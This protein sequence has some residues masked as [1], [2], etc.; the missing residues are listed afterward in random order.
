MTP[1]IQKIPPPVPTAPDARMMQISERVPALAPDLAQ[2]LY[3]ADAPGRTYMLI[4]ATLRADVAGLFDLDVQDCDAL[5]LFDGDAAEQ[6]GEAAPWLADLSIGDPATQSLR[7]HADF[8]ARHWPTGTSVLIQ[9]DADL[10]QIKRHLRRFVRLPVTDDGKRRYFRFWDGRILPDFLAAIALD[11]A[12]A[13]RMCVTDAQHEVRYTCLTSDGPHSM[14][15]DMARLVPLPVSVMY[16]TNADFDATARADQEARY[17]RIAT[18]IKQDF[19]TQLAARD[20]EDVTRTV[21]AAAQRFARF[22]FSQH[23]HIHFFAV[24]SV[25]YGIG[26]E[27][28][29]TTGRLQEI[30]RSDA[31]ERARFDAFR[32]WFDTFTMAA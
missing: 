29:D 18:R 22:G 2:M 6:Y 5:C 4:D 19:H 1:L 9:T 17:A 15:P 24:W 28:A 25:L 23:A 16:L 31:P 20:L 12:R 21:R 13:R 27:E 30:C 26:F 14:V 11:G 8:F 7:F 32:S 10:A 3:G